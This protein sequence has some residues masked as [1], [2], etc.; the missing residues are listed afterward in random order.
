MVILK[1]RIADSADPRMGQRATYEGEV[2]H[3]WKAQ[4][5]DELALAAQVA[6][7]LHPEN[8]GADALRDAA[9]RWMRMIHARFISMLTILPASGFHGLTGT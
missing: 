3:A 1:K 8:G 7:V 4:V 9:C 6:V 5:G 2:L